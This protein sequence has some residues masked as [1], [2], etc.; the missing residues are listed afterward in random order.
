MDY[1][2]K[3]FE[4]D[5]ETYLLN[6]G[7]YIQKNMVGF[8]KAN[9]IYLSELIYFIRSTQENEWERYEKIYGV[10]SEKKFLKRFNEEV[11]THGIL[12]VLRN[13]IN[14]RGVKLKVCY[15]KPESTLNQKL[16]KNYNSNILSV[17]RQFAYSV[18]NNNTID[19]VLTLNGIPLVALELKNQITGQSV[20]NA[21]KQ[22][23][24]DRN[25]K[26]YCFHFNKRF[27]VYFAVDL[28][29][30]F[31]ATE[32]KGKDTFFLPFNQGSGGA[33]KV[34]GSG[35]PENPNGYNTSYL[36][37]NVLSKDSFLNIIQRFLHV[38]VERKKVLKDDKEIMKLSKKLIFPRFHQL[39][40]VTKLIDDVKINGSGKNYLIQHS[41]G[42]GKSNSIAWSCYRLAS[43][44]DEHN[45]SIFTSVIVVTDRKV[46]DNQLQDTISSFD[47]AYGL[48]ETIGDGKSS[49]DLKDAINDGKKIIVTTLQKFP[50]IYEEVENNK[51]KRFAIIVD[52]AH[53]S[54]TGSSAQKLKTALADNEEALR[55]FARIEGEEEANIEDFEDKLIKELLTHGKH[56]NLSF[57][58]FTATPKQK[59]LEM[60]GTQHTDGTF[61]PFH[62]YSMKQAIEE[63]FIH[64]VLANYM[65]Y[66]TCFK[67]AKSTPD[68]PELPESEAKKAIKRYESLH[69]YNL[70]QKTAVM[71]E[72]FRDV[73]MHKIG[74]RAKA[75]VVTASRLHAVRYFL[76]FKRYI[77]KKGYKDLDVLVAFS[78][79][80]KDKDEEYTETGLNI[81]KEGSRISEKQLPELF[82]TDEFNILVVAE[83]Y[84]TG[85]DEPL[86]HTMFVDKKLSGVKAVQ[87]LSRL[88]RTMLG[89]TDTFVMD[90][91]NEAEDIKE[92]FEPFY[93]ETVLDKEINVNLI[94]DTKI[95]IRQFLLYNDSDVE[96][97]NNIYYKE[98][99]SSTDLGKITSLYTPILKQYNNLSLEERF[100]FKKSVRN[101]VKWYAYIV[102]ITR[103]FDKDLQKEY[104]FL[105][106]M[107]KV[108]PKN[109]QE[110]VDLED[111]IKLE[112]YKLEKSFEG[113]VI[114]GNDE[115]KGVLTN[116]ETV[117]VSKGKDKKD[118]LLENII[119]HINQRYMGIFSE[120]DRVIVETMFN[121]VKL[122]DKKLKKYAKKNNMEV[123]S[124]SIF[125]KVFADVAQE[126]YEEQMGAFKKLF[127][128]K[129]F[130]TAIM[131]EIA[132]ETYRELR[133]Q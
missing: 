19:M 105:K 58:A 9:C 92:A 59:T 78:G 6:H 56:K 83:K 79:S 63:E 29:E 25:P 84:Q 44:H 113:E 74:G 122:E 101:Y 131:N 60:F 127:E 17:V 54:Q 2:E 30:V 37:E 123:F 111:K 73:T 130:Y 128:D 39:D 94:Y 121:K 38:S 124:E 107:D 120:G 3:R 109:S 71:I 62:I 90:F 53:S 115:N 102:Q 41:A 42:S 82:S 64:D 125:P 18:E 110:Q 1:K 40:V 68:N 69:P 112:F 26:E 93:K 28:F 91:V 76:E 55:E 43:L 103:M 65:T 23:M 66:K 12:H 47:H 34:G 80:V 89:K 46:L 22:F 57:L 106:Y 133:N 50:V 70:Q 98:K 129:S 86:L 116:V 77:D 104:N 132:K 61:H 8:D 95:S 87:T 85:F 108:L 72:Y 31:M 96:K 81:T 14:D 11:N 21:K 117:D 100:M 48:V 33:G 10:E 5:I 32:L 67:I 97:F 119:N 4:E 114:L 51:G 20:E 118:E 7:G 15:F 52:E 36:W 45:N 16:V 88:N 13:G 27:L 126:C 49:K 24:Y 35:N 99:Q 75:M